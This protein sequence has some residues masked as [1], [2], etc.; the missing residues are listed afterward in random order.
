MKKAQTQ[1]Q[2]STERQKSTQKKSLTQILDNKEDF[3]QMILDIDIKKPRNAY[4]YFTRELREKLNL[5]GSITDKA[6]EFSSKYQKL[7]ES[8]KAKYEK[9]AEDDR[10]RYQ[11]HMTLVRKY[12][13]DKPF[14]ENATPYSIFIDEKLRDA[15]EQGLDLKESKEKFKSLWENDLTPDE[16]RIYKEK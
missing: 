8:E 6:T 13:L 5:K 12:V 7:T 15:R 3:D 9:M 14:K 4:N 11:E 10:K 1:R 2:A 16:K